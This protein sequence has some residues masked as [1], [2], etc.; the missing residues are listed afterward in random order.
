[1]RLLVVFAHP[2]AESYGGALYDLA[3]RTLRAA[4]HELRCHDL[5]RENFN[6]VLSTEEWQGYLTRTDQI[7]A[8]NPDHVANL[9]W[10]EGLLVI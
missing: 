7:I 1:M 9:Q 4:G 5:Y 6:P 8:K 2:C 3:C 10:A